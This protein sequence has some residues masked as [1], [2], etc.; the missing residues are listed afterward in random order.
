LPP[1]KV[2]F[3]EL[4]SSLRVALNH[5]EER[6]ERL[7]LKINEQKVEVEKALGELLSLASG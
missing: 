5:R 3:Q 7:R 1:E 6:H 4:L 2:T